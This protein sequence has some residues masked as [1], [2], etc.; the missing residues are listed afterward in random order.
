MTWTVL[1]EVGISSLVSV[2]YCLPGEPGT[3]PE[4]VMDVVAEIVLEDEG[5]EDYIQS[6]AKVAAQL[7]AIG[8]P[9]TY[10]PFFSGIE[11][12][13]RTFPDTL[14]QYLR[15]RWTNPTFHYPS[16]SLLNGS[17]ASIGEGPG[18]VSARR[19]LEVM[20]GRFGAQVRLSIFGDRE[21]P[22]Q[23]MH[24]KSTFCA[25]WAED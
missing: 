16:T 13:F 4:E 3:S 22:E 17:L 25:T 5:L 7:S 2:C 10:A 20:A 19:A 18:R 12:E 24:C 21:H 9:T 6:N 14:A 1:L 8:H 15:L 23:H 11:D